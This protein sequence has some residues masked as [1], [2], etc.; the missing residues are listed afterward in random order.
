MFM[1]LFT[2][3]LRWYKLTSS[4]EQMMH[5]KEYQKQMAKHINKVA[6]KFYDQQFKSHIVCRDVNG[7]AQFP[8]N[9]SQVLSYNE[10]N[11]ANDPSK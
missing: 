4:T 7:Q 8:Q 5:Q 3:E 10:V 2:D 11:C 1:I 6:P 9:L